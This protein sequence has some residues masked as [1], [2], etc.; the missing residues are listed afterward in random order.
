MSYYKILLN[1]N[2]YEFIVYL[3]LQP[4]LDNKHHLSKNFFKIPTWKKNFFWRLRNASY[5]LSTP[6][7]NNTEEF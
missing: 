2:C 3:E 7:I 4:H 6:T 1:Q 5:R